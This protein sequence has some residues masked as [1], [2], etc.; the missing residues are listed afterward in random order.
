MNM[1]SFYDKNCESGEC[2]YDLSSVIL[3]DGSASSGHYICFLRPDVGNSPDSWL[4]LSDDIVVETD[5]D[6][7]LQESK[8]DDAFRMRETSKSAYILQYVKKKYVLFSITLVNLY[9]S[10]RFLI[11]YLSAF[12]NT[13]RR[14]QR[15]A[16]LPVSKQKQNSLGAF[17]TIFRGVY[18]PMIAFPLILASSFLIFLK[19]QTGKK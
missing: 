17:R 13:L 11:V 16:I 8:G 18:N 7:V 2:D 1:K 3:H 19:L 12:R 15:N 10:C 9:D 6:R 5:F 4:R 14:T